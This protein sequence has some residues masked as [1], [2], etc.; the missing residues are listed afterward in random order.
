MSGSEVISGRRV[1]AT[2]LI[3]I[4]ALALSVWQPAAAQSTDPEPTLHVINPT[5]SVDVGSLPPVPLVQSEHSRKPFFPTTDPQV[6]KDFKDLLRS[7]SAGMHT[8]QPNVSDP[9]SNVGAPLAVGT[10]LEGLAN[11]DNAALLGIALLPPDSNLGVGP[12]HVFETVNVLGRISSKTGTTLSTFYLGDFFALDLFLASESDPRVIYDAISGRWLATYLEFST[13]TLQSSIVLMASSSSDPTGTWCRYQLGNP[14]TENFLQDFPQVGVSD[15]KIVVTYNGFTFNNNNA[16]LGAGYYVL[17]KAEVTGC[18]SAHFVRMA[19]TLTRVSPMPAQSLS[20][21]SDLFLPMHDV[22]GTLTLLTVK[23]VP[24]VS[25]VTETATPL[26]IRNWLPPPPADQPA[27][28]ALLET[29]D[30]RLTSVAWQN[31]SLWVAGNEACTPPGDLAVRSCLRLVEVTT[32]PITVRQDFSYGGAGAHF[33]YPALRPDGTSNLAVVF[34]ASSTTMFA[35]V[36]AASRLASDPLN[37]LQPSSMLRA[38]GGAQTD[39]SGRMGDYSG[40][41][42]DPSDST[43]IWVVA[44]YIYSTQGADW[45]SFIARLSVTGGGGPDLITS[46]IS[47]P[48]AA[49][50]VGGTMTVTDTALNQGTASANSSTTRYYLSTDGAALSQLLTGS[51]GVPALAAGASSVGTVTV[52]IPTN[53]STGTY[54]LLACADDT[55]VVFESSET[56]NCRASSTTVVVGVPDLIE[57]G[58][59]G[60]ATAAVGGTMTVS[61]TA[62]NQGTGPTRASSTRYYLSTNGVALTQLLTGSR[63][64]PVLAAGASSAGTVTVTIPAT[65]LTGTYFLLACADD[66]KAVFESNET[67]NCAAAGGSVVVGTPDLIE[68]AVSGPA[69]AAVGGMITVT[70]TALNQGTGPTRASSTRYYLSTNGVALTQLLTGSRAVPVLAA[71]ASSAGT[72]TVTIP[73]TAAAGTFFLLACADD[74]KVVFESSETNNCMAAAGS[75]VVGVPDLVE[76]AVTG[77]ATAAVGGTMTVTD[78]ALNQGTGPTRVSS[79]RYYLSTDGIALTQLLTGSRAVAVLGAGALSAGSVVVTIPA[80]TSTGTY[81]L[82]ACADD[83]KIVFESNEANNCAAAGGSVVV[84][85]PDLVETTVSGP[86]AAMVGH[87]MVVSDTALNQGTGPARASSTRYYLSTNGVALTQ[88]LTGS[89]GVPALAAGASSPGTVTVTIPATASAGTYFLLACADD[90]KVVFENNETN[91]CRASVSQVVVGP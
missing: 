8:P 64:V 82:L 56:N 83:T 62:L 85:T 59:S 10:S 32:N 61:D 20:S 71:G 58:V 76:T 39:P 48:P 90:T 36:R 12:N 69:T 66:V 68:T 31:G 19:P 49:A 57:N 25:T 29:N 23:G 43:Q 37:T 67:N 26:A 86:A 16:Y 75:V 3:A 42:V 5:S 52:T 17:N 51:R 72:V 84:G 46:A 65:A 80:T 4:V 73:T 70:D 33:Y 34:T 63:A 40:A 27:S 89:R 45:A 11:I 2:G 78:T 13:F 6:L 24:G 53:A 9:L 38:G 47:N 35:S 91:N 44:E 30:D 74:M 28:S 41:A 81:F 55:K 21:T 15:D 18:S 22:A 87:T 60:P 54:F 88:L 7:L 1:S 77:P 79:T 50:S 14:T